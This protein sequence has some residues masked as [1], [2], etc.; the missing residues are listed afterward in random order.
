M[1]Q[2]YD[3]Q[4]IDAPFIGNHDT[5]RPAGFFSGDLQKTKMAGGLYLTMSGGPFV[6]YGEE[7]GM[8]GSRIDEDKRGPMQ[9]SDTVTTGMTKGPPGMDMPVRLFAAEDVQDGD[10]AS[11]LNYYRRAIRLRN[12]NP[13]IARGTVSVL[14]GIADPEVCAVAK[15]WNG[16]RIILVI[17][18]S[19][20]TKVVEFSRTANQYEGIRGYLSTTGASVILRGDQLTLPP[21]SIVVLK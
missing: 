4:A 10:A 8:T 21:M 13:E 5:A 2:E 11:L 14:G 6:Y 1:L 3:T 17:N 19:E 18:T 16:S 15:G 7:L 12:E 20:E 9:W